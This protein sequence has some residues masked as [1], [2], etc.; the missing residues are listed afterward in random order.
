MQPSQDF[1]TRLLQIRLG[2]Q[3]ALL[4]MVGVTIVGA[5]IWNLA[6]ARTS[7]K[8]AAELNQMAALVDSL[9]DVARAQRQ[10]L[11]PIE[12]RLDSFGLTS[13]EVRGILA[14]K[15]DLAT[16]R[17]LNDKLDGIASEL[18]LNDSALERMRV[19]LH[20]RLRQAE[21]VEQDSLATLRRTFQGQ[22]AA[23]SERDSLVRDR[24]H[25]L[26]LDTRLTAL[27]H[28]MDGQKKWMAVR[29][30]ATFTSLAMITAHVLAEP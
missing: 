28:R 18:A 11:H 2:R 21:A 24:D 20:D 30:V 10:Q 26:A 23:R 19:D 27:E 9:S 15:A 6:L 1:E 7:E 14:N 25:A 4:A 8:R 3:Q 13:N 29:D 22:L 16:V 12:K 17:S 5:L